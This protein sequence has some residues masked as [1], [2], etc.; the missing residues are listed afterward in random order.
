MERDVNSKGYKGRLYI[1]TGWDMRR[2]IQIMRALDVIV[3]DSDPGTEAAGLSEALA[4]FF[5]AKVVGPSPLEGLIHKQGMPKNNRH[6]GRYHYPLDQSPM[7][8]QNA[9]M[10]ED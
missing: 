9:I 2:Q 10:G 3:F 5:G 6:K 4:T 8:F 7:A 1:E